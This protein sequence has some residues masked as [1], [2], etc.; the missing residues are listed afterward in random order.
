M[1]KLY[2]Y[3][4]IN[5]VYYLTSSMV[6][7]QFSIIHTCLYTQVFGD[8]IIIYLLFQLI[9]YSIALIFEYHIGIYSYSISTH[10]CSYHKN[11]A[12]EEKE[13]LIAAAAT[14]KE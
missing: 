8:Y 3:V 11:V 13:R 12:V 5:T 14:I 1:I 10:R 6:L 9:Y 7:F 2:H 4:Y